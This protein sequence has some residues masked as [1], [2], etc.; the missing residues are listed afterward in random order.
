[1]KR[2]VLIALPLLALTATGAQAQDHSGH[3]MPGAA[4]AEDN[5]PAAED[6]PA[7]PPPAV[8]ADHAAD[9]YYDPAQMAQARKMLAYEGGGMPNSMLMIDR[10]EWRPGPGGDGYNWEIEGWTGGDIDRLAIKSKGE[11]DF[12]GKAEKIEL[13]AGWFHALDPWFNLRV[14]VR[15]DL[16]P[17]PR[18]THAVLA[19]EGLAPYW[20]ETEGE[21][22]LSQKGEVTA[23]GEVSYDQ[24]ITQRIVLQPRAEVN[25]SAQDMPQL[26]TGAGLTSLELGLRLR[27][28]FVR[29]FAPYVGVNW[30][31]KLGKTARYARAEGESPGG[32]RFVTGVR[33]WF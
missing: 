14:G 2:T 17:Q 12:T 8:P 18:R 30:E 31:R 32:L 28:E 13:Q 29:E 1:M 19:I 23:R 26:E 6:V 24:M 16:Q 11:G 7:A 22:F 33:F 15:Q 3:V 9:A 5:V 25:L 21:L 20:F 10:L 27:Y 4:P